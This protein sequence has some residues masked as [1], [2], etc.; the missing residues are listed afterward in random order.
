MRNIRILAV[1]MVMLLSAMATARMNRTSQTHHIGGI[2]GYVEGRNLKS[3]A[4]GAVIGGVAGGVVGA[5]IGGL[6]TI[7]AGGAGAIPGAEIGVAVGGF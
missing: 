4:E 6:A 3:A 7:P 1:A 5:L 2:V